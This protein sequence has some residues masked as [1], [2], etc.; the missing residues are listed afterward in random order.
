LGGTVTI[1]EMRRYRA[2]WRGTLATAM[3]IHMLHHPDLGAGE[4]AAQKLTGMMVKMSAGEAASKVF[5]QSDMNRASGRNGDQISDWGEGGYV[6][7]DS[8]GSSVACVF[9][10]NGAFGIAA[11]VPELG[12]FL[13]PAAK[14]MG[15]AHPIPLLGINDPLNQTVMAT[16]GA[17]GP[18]GALAAAAVAL[19]VMDKDQT[20]DQAMTARGVIDGGRVQALWCPKGIRTTPQSCQF[21]T[22]PKG[23]GLATFDK[24]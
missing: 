1:D 14:Q 13:A 19:G 3:G 23:H 24:F 18:K 21:A 12:V 16:A 15:V 5:G 17:G 22:D 11:M 4:D 10:M 9:T 20:L 6:I 2:H 7:G 8:F